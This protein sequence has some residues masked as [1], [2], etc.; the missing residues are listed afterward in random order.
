MHTSYANDCMMAN[1][2]D[3]WMNKWMYDV[4]DVS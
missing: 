1:A 4:C 2:F 3:A